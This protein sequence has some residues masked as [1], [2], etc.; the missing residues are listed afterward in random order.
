MGGFQRHSVY[1]L[2]PKNHDV[3][4]AIYKEGRARTPLDYQR[5][6]NLAFYRIQGKRFI[7]GFHLSLTIRK[8]LDRH[9]LIFQGHHQIKEMEEQMK[10]VD[11]WRGRPAC[12]R[13][14]PRNQ[15][16]A[17]SLSVSI[18]ML[19]SELA[20]MNHRKLMEFPQGIG[21]AQCFDTD[22]LLFAHPPQTHKMPWEIRSSRGDINLLTHSPTSTMG[23][24]SPSSA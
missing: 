22:F 9:T 1:D 24:T 2:F 17:G 10:R 11:R 23:S 3:I 5:Y 21:K 13:N 18:Q 8:G 19:K 16:F 4:H 14:G 12:R 6:D 7:W 20:W 15:K